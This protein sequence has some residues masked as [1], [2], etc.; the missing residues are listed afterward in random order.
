MMSCL[1]DID[2]NNRRNAMILIPRTRDTIL[3][4]PSSSSSRFSAIK[5]S[6]GEEETLTGVLSSEDTALPSSI[7]LSGSD[8]AIYFAQRDAAFP[9]LS[10]GAPQSRKQ[11]ARSVYIVNNSLAKTGFN[12]PRDSPRPEDKNPWTLCG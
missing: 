9:Y 11:P 7:R 3:D 1:S 2:A 10:R 4:S 5:G 12:E 8:N 6:R